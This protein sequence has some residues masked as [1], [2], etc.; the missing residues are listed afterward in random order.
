MHRFAL[1]ITLSILLSLAPMPARAD[2]LMGNPIIAASNPGDQFEPAVARD[3]EH[4][5][6]LAVWEQDISG[7]YAIVAR[8][9]GGDGTPLGSSFFVSDSVT[10][11]TDP[12]VVYDPVN[13]R[14]V[15]VWVHEY[16]ASDTD[17]MGRFIPWVG[18][19]TGLLP[20]SIEDPVTLQLSPAVAYTPAPVNELFVVWQDKAGF[21]PATIRAKRIDPD[22]GNFLTPSF[23]V[24][25][26]TTYDRWN[27]QLAWNHEEDRYLVVYERFQGA[28]EEDVYAA[29]VLYSG[30]VL[31][32]DL[33]IA[34]FPAE[35]NQ[36]AVAACEG[37]W[38]VLWKGGQGGSAQ[39][40]AR[41]VAGDLTLGAITNLSA[42]FVDQR[43]PKVACNPHGHEFFTVREATFGGGKIG[44]SGEFLDLNGTPFGEFNLFV[45]P[46]GSIINYTRPAAAVSTT[47]ARAYVIAESDRED[48]VHQDL[49]GRWVDMSTFT[50]D[51]ETGGTSRWSQVVP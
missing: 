29:E 26:D 16:S 42:P 41:P 35:E 48:L 27:P 28:G 10:D 45:S 33:G 4:D 5:R 47:D 38:M 40:Y 12:D 49:I 31:T 30:T 13:G 2:P 3:D 50:D 44:A 22:N 34:G 21:D 11:Q 25:G 17:L 9:I 36:V 39:V 18:L 8:L 32:S 24:V 14:F 7:V 1:L 43:W 37:T 46:V 6:Y 15:V 51:F 23:P 20:F 19:D